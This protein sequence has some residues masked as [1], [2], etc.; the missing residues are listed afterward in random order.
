MFRRFDRPH[1]QNLPKKLAALS[2]LIATTEWQTRCS[3]SLQPLLTSHSIGSEPHDNILRKK[4]ILCVRFAFRSAAPQNLKSKIKVA[5][6]ALF[7]VVEPLSRPRNTRP[8]SRP[9]RRFICL[10]FARATVASKPKAPPPSETRANKIMWVTPPKTGTARLFPMTLAVAGLLFLA[11][12]P[13]LGQ[14]QT[15][16]PPMPRSGTMTLCPRAAIPT[17]KARRAHSVESPHR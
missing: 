9:R 5:P 8:G 3:L 11:A 4:N 6:R 1:F 13:M 15:F 16:D 12:A 7:V 14:A 17:T 10:S 2:T